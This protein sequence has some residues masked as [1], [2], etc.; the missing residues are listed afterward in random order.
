MKNKRSEELDKEKNLEVLHDRARQVEDFRFK[1]STSFDKYL[2]T[3]ATGSLYL[4]VNFSA[5]H[6]AHFQK[7]CLLATG[8]IA[9]IVA[10]IASLISIY[11]SSL[12]HEIGLDFVFR[13]ITAIVEGEDPD[14]IKMNPLWN[15]AIHSF[16]LISMAA[17]II[18]IVASAAFYYK[19]L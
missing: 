6:G 18:G 14:K 11:L 7:N 19:M 4:S 9:L 10:I 5:T 8:W 15:I 16:T 2:L 1:L 12:V 3:F 13:Q 17:F